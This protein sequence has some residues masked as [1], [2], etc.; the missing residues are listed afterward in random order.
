MLRGRRHAPA[1]VANGTLVAVKPEGVLIEWD[2]PAQP[3]LVTTGAE[4]EIEHLKTS[5][6]KPVR[7][8]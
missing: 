8:C 1:D 3:M 7:R 5:R 6:S 2:D 4:I